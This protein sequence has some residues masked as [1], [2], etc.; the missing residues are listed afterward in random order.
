MCGSPRGGRRCL[1]AVAA[2]SQLSP[3]AHLCESGFRAGFGDELFSL[4]PAD[5]VCYAYDMDNRRNATHSPGSTEIGRRPL[6]AEII[7]DGT[8]LS[9]EGRRSQNHYR[10]Y[11]M[12]F[13]PLF[14]QSESRPSQSDFRGGSAFYRRSLTASASGTSRAVSRTRS[15]RQVGKLNLCPGADGGQ[16]YGRFEIR[17]L[18][19]ASRY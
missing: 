1:S 5:F 13:P 11:E 10:W 18:A 7:F 3:R 8:K 2:H 12:H 4:T 9:I 19:S 15:V 14:D 6:A 16:N 17:G